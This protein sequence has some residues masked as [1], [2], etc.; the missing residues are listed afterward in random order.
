MYCRYVDNIFCIFWNKEQIQHLDEKFNEM[1]KDMKIIILTCQ[2][3]K[4]LY[5]DK[6][7]VLK[8][9]KIITSTYR[10]PAISS[11]LMNFN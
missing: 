1:H 5:F 2:E 8:D 6:Q 7:V 10:K 4:L 3:S 9:N 11:V